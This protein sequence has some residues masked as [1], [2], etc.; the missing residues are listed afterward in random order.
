VDSG[1]G[2]KAPTPQGH[3]VLELL[4]ELI[5]LRGS[6]VNVATIAALELGRGVRVEV[7]TGLAGR[8]LVLL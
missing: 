1:L 4:V 5:D 6:G 3:D 8:P 2:G 7:V